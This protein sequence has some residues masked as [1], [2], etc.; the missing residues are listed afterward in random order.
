V[1]A[2]GGLHVISCQQNASPRMDRQLIGRCA[3]HGDPGSAEK[4]ISL[5][6]RLLAG[7]LTVRLLRGLNNDKWVASI[8]ALLLNVAQRREEY[9]QGA[10]RN[11]LLRNDKEM[12]R[13]FAF[14]GIKE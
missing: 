14:G 10:E 7:S 5:D 9:R 4:F 2:K 1:A 3:R 11:R 8:G 13:W 6:G 12:S